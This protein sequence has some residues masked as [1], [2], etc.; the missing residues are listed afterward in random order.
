LVA[1]IVAGYPFFADHQK[2][3]ERTIPVVELVPGVDPVAPAPAGG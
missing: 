3:V 1:R 2:G